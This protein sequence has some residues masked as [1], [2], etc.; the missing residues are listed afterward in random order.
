MKKYDILY[1]IIGQTN[2]EIKK[3]TIEAENCKQ[4]K[5]KFKAESPDTRIFD[6][7][8]SA[9]NEYSATSGGGNK[10]LTERF[11]K[12][13]PKPIGFLMHLGRKTLIYKIDEEKGCIYVEHD[14]IYTTKYTKYRKEGKMVK[15]CRKLRTNEKT[16][17]KYFSISGPFLYL[18]NM[19]LYADMRKEIEELGL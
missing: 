3:T 4:A 10:H 15:S 1:K 17:E 18:H 7:C 8:V 16:G 5:I 2:T 13:N 14:S 6:A 9:D 11:F 12:D 19:V